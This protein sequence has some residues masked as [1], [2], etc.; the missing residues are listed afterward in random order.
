[1]SG[2]GD[3]I[4]GMICCGI[5]LLAFRIHVVDFVVLGLG[6]ALLTLGVWLIARPS[7]LGMIFDGGILLLIAAWNFYGYYVLITGS[8]GHVV[9]SPVIA[10]AQVCW[11]VY[12]IKSYPRFALAVAMQPSEVNIRWLRSLVQSTLKAKPKKDPGVISFTR[13]GFFINERWKARLLP[14]VAVF[15]MSTGSF[16]GRRDTLLAARD[17][18]EIVRDKKRLLGRSHKLTL[19]VGQR[20]L[21][22]T[23]P[24]ESFNRLQEWMAPV[25]AP[26]TPLPLPVA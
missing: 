10:I 9:V 19:R 1:M 20:E 25:L 18:L 5:G 13:R 22:I 24:E 4:W 26:D 2:I 3:I 16:G 12:R 23:M 11:G 6:V 8:R 7:P 21:K 15:V 14:E 17:G